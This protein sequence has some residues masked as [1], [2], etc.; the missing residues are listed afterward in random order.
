MLSSWSGVLIVLEVEERASPCS[1]ALLTLAGQDV[2]V[3]GCD[4]SP[5][6]AVQPHSLQ[7]GGVWPTAGAGAL[8]GLFEHRAEGDEG[9]RAGGLAAVALTACQ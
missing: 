1:A 3:S 9:V 4:A 5:A 2:S 8:E 7:L 6:S